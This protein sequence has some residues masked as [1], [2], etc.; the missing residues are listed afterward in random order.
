MP[1]SRMGVCA[2]DRLIKGRPNPSGI[3]AAFVSG[4]YDVVTVLISF[5]R[6][7]GMHG[8][9]YVER[10][11]E[12]VAGCNTILVCA[13]RTLVIGNGR[14]ARAQCRLRPRQIARSRPLR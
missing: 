9:D 14:L 7:N 11:S 1:H 4:G 2:T 13:V 8:E 5:S 10:S 3:R 12:K 6:Q